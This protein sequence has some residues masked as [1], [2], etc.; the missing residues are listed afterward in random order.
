MKHIILILS[1]VIPTCMFSQPK[2]PVV[3]DTA[4]G[5]KAPDFTQTDTAGKNVS[6]HDFKGKYVLIDFWASW[7]KP[8]RKE[9]PFLVQAFNT[10]KDKGFTIIS[11]S[12]DPPGA[13]EKWLQAIQHDGIGGWTH[14]SDLNFWDNAV[15]RLYGIRSIPM[16]FL[17]D[18]QG[19][20]VA[21]N[22]RG[23][24]LE[25]KLKEVMKF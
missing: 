23:E 12:L 25:A 18:K 21:K 14:L 16:N 4:V 8:C 24:E 22:L 17:V 11:I 9:N 20:I 2:Q 1:L 5:D 10:Y 13:R 15:S 6:L 19:V 3:K 7:C